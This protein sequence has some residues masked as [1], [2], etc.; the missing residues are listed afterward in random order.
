MCEVL[1]VS[2][3]GFYAWRS[4]PESERSKR[5]RELIEEIRKIH[6][7]R[8]MESYGSPRVHRELLSRGKSCSEN[9]VAE[10]MRAHGLVARTRRKY[11]VTTDSAH[12]LPI[13]NNVLNRD[14]EQAAPNRVW[15]ADITFIWTQEGWLY[16]AVV[17]DAHSRKIVGWS[18]SHRMHAGLVMDALRMAIGRRCP[19]Q[20]ERLL[21]HSDRGS[22]YASQAFQDLLREHNIT[23]SMS[24]K[25]NCWDNAMMESFFA[26]LKKERVHHESYVTR[27]AARQSVFEYIEL[28]YNIRRRHSALGYLSPEQ[29]E[30]AA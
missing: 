7:D 27:E 2:R 28:F 4:R 8:D 1:E 15:L 20:A 9:T 5:H 13:A 12:L 17:L 22:Q 30:Q 25:G 19:D 6:A 24:R 16:L 11:R 14:F 21:H 18:M 23:C 10:L 29:Y 26:T 3:S